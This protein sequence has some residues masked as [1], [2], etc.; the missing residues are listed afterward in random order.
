[1]QYRQKQFSFI[2]VFLVMLLLLIGCGNTAEN[3]KKNFMK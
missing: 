3:A 2:V 1:M